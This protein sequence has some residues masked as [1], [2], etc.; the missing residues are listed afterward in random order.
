MDKGIAFRRLVEEQKLDAALFLGDDV[1]DLNA[2]RMARRLREENIC[3]AWGIGV[4]SDD[5]PEDL[6]ATADF[7]AEGVLDVEE[8]LAWLLTA[9]RASST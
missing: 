2:L 4:Q 1:S 7:L 8:L 9:R 3:D 6:A 5:A